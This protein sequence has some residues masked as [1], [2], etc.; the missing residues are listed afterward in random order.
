MGLTALLI[1]PWA[2]DIVDKT[3][4]DRRIFLVVA[5]V[6][7]AITASAILLVHEGNT[8]HMLIF[9]TKV[10]EGIAGSFIG[11]ALAALTLACFGPDHF[12][13]IMTSN[14]FVSYSC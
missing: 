3:A 14:I 11:P 12:D 2:G 9:A 4:I 1:Q 10:I 8:D 13:S 7:T 5:S 6:V